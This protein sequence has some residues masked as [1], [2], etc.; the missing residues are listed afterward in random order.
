M[1]YPD[2]PVPIGV[3]RDVDRPTYEEMLHEQV[4]TAT[5]QRGAGD[6]AKLYSAADTWTV[7]NGRQGGAS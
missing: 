5:R 4:E 6:L 1:D 3:F 2:L 7:S